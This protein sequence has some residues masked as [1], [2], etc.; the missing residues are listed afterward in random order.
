MRRILVTALVGIAA[1][2]AVAGR[3]EAIEIQR[4]VSPRGIVAWLVEDH[5]IP[6]V[7]VEFA[8]DGGSAQDPQETPGV[9]NML[10][11]LLD[12]GAGPLDSKAF[13]ARLDELSIRLSYDTGRDTFTGSLRT[14]EEN[15][16][17]AVRLARI[18]LSVPRFDREPVERIRAQILSSIRREE[19]DPGS[20]A[21]RALLEAAYPDHPYGH[22]VDGTF[23]S[24]GA[25]TVDDL[26]GYHARVLAK[27]N[28]TVAVVGAI[29][30]GRLGVLLDRMFGGLPQKANLA[31]VADARPVTN[32]R[33]DI[34]MDIPQ[35][36]IRLIAPGIMRAD[37]KFIDA[38]VAT[39]I[40]GGGGFG[41]RLFDEI[42]EKRGL[43]YSVGLGLGALDHSG[44]VSGGTSTRADQADEVI[45]LLEDEISRYAE[46]G[47]TEAEL[48]EAKNYLIG[49][50]PLRFTTSSRIAGQL[51]GIQL[52]DLGIDYVDRRNEM[53]DDLT[54]EDVSAAAARLFADGELTIVRVGQ[55]SS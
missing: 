7:S 49:S 11:G 43:A 14:L 10:S 18:S 28:L 20:V 2:A 53:I 37:A 3:A 9:A 8:F 44:L 35:T 24:V 19:R 51:L 52:D 39:F 23:D 32:E 6:I 27:S 15:L 42:R 33:I 17:S 4:V 30:A 1:V 26:R 16:D 25:I 45:A 41:S 38:Y 36:N 21:G 54:I 22:P 46:T 29:D 31:R 5:A 34:D 50:Y 48:Q 13:Q 40:L 12:E 47:P 55:P